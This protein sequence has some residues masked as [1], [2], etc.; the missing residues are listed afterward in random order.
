M[1]LS[2]EQLLEVVK[3][4]NVEDLKKLASSENMQ[5]AYDKIRLKGQQTF[6]R[7]AEFYYSL[8]QKDRRQL[9]EGIVENNWIK[10]VK[11]FKKLSK[12]KH[13]YF[14]QALTMSV[15]TAMVLR[16]DKRQIEFI[17]K[18]FSA[19]DKFLPEDNLRPQLQKQKSPADTLVL[20]L[21]AGLKFFRDESTSIDEIK[22]AYKNFDQTQ[23]DYGL[24]SDKFRNY[25]EQTD[26]ANVALRQYYLTAHYAVL[27]RKAVFHQEAQELETVLKIATESGVPLPLDDAL[28]R[29]VCIWVQN[30]RTLRNL[31]SRPDNQNEWLIVKLLL[32]YGAQPE[33]AYRS[34]LII[35]E[36]HETR[37]RLLM[38][39]KQ[40]IEEPEPL[41][42]QVVERDST[43]EVED[44]LSLMLAKVKDT[45]QT[46][47]QQ[48]MTRV[49]K[50]LREPQVQER[51]QQ[52]QVMVQQVATGGKKLSK[53]ALQALDETSRRA[54]QQLQ[55]SKM[56]QTAHQ[57]LMQEVTERQQDEDASETDPLLGMR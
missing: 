52:A 2:P 45:S 6:Q 50:L 37:T 49:A 23:N 18:K 41:V 54:Y 40:T 28:F 53:Q 36:N 14:S 5:Q 57:H 19:G 16:C 33:T 51:V 39:N 10:L 13:F 7:L 9:Y 17:L 35:V 27:L 24:E 31:G 29:A 43:D 34:A 22:K 21:N 25:Y 44:G 42:A 20:M 30:K 26:E 47:A 32:D 3:Q 46:V 56:A 38:E 15:R 11:F 12:K 1:P 48:S 4:I 8:R 55:R